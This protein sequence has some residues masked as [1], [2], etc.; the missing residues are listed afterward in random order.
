MIAAS[1]QKALNQTDGKEKLFSNVVKS[2]AKDHR[3][4][5]SALIFLAATAIT[6]S[7][8]WLIMTA[9]PPNNY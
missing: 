1:Q 2:N 6:W 5:W 4:A 3:L 9:A 7:L 8:L